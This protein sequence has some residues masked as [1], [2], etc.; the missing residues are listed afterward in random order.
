ME[1]NVIRKKFRNANF[2][3]R[4]VESAINQFQDRFTNNTDDD[5]FIIPPNFFDLPK[6]FILLEVPFC[7]ENEKVSKSFISKFHKFTN[8]KFEIAIKWNTKKIRQLFSL[9]D[10]NPYPSC[11]IYEGTCTTYHTSYIGETRRNTVVRWNEHNNPTKN[12][13]PANHIYHN[14]DHQYSWKILIK[15]PLR[16]RLRKNLEA[17]F[18]ALKRPK[19]N[20]QLES[21]KLLLFRNGVT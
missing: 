3:S 12:S 21:K 11:V 1:N 7:E 2:P 17:S 19:L 18:I 16:T 5:E 15:A 9:K 6:P 8:N 20:E 10:R 4:F 14:P 13:E